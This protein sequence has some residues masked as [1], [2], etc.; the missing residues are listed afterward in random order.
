MADE[1]DWSC[2]DGHS[3]FFDP[4]KDNI[5]IHFWLK[6][7][8]GLLVQNGKQ[9]NLWFMVSNTKQARLERRESCCKL[10]LRCKL[11]IISAVKQ[12]GNHFFVFFKKYFLS[13][14]RIKM[15]WCILGWGLLH[16]PALLKWLH[17]FMKSCDIENSSSTSLNVVI[18]SSGWESKTSQGWQLSFEENNLLDKKDF[19][20]KLRW[21]VMHP[22]TCLAKLIGVFKIKCNSWYG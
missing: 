22:R 3:E 8:Y 13:L 19:F 11:I 20:K 5:Y 18:N 16:Y 6:P 21:L 12:T 7:P 14:F 2:W 15:Y 10:T 17:F 4:G 9:M 1:D